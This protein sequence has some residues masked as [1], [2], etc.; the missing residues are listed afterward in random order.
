MLTVRP[1]TPLLAAARAATLA[2]PVA[3]HAILLVARAQVRP[4]AFPA[5]SA[6]APQPAPQQPVAGEAL[7]AAEAQASLGQARLEAREL[8]KSERPELA[9]AK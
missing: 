7:Q 6:P 3:P 9:S 4:S 5:T 8:T 1:P 2:S